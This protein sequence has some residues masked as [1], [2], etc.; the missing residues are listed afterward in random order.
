MGGGR[1]WRSRLA[2]PT[3]KRTILLQDLAFN[4]VAFDEGDIRRC[5]PGS[6]EKGR[7]YHREGAVRA[8][9]ADKGGQ[10]LI[11]SVRATRAPPYHVFVEI[12]DSDP[13]VLSG[14]C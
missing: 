8:L 6:F 12:E 7:S 9:L 5:L 10:R 13:V 2:A 4:S 14:R 1:D 11:P 3:V